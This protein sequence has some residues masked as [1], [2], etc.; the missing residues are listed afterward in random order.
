MKKIAII[1]KFDTS[2]GIADGQAVKTNIV[3]EEL[4]R[5]YGKNSVTRINTYAWKKHPVSLFARC[6][7]AVW[8]HKD[9][10]F[11]TDAGGIKVFPWLLLGANLFSDCKIHYLV[12]GG[13][14]PA[15][16]ENRKLRLWLLK[17]LNGIYV[18]TATMQ[19]AL[20]NRGLTNVSIVRNCKRLTPL[21][22]TDLHY[23][24]EGPYKLCTFS[25]VMREKGIQEAVEAVCAINMQMGK[26]VYTLDIYG[27]IDPEQT[28][29]FEVLQM[30]FP[31]F[32]RYCGT[33]PYDR[34]VTVLKDY[35]A[36]LRKPACPTGLMIGMGYSM[37]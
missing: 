12:V 27:Q 22:E 3:T 5:K 21:P 8:Y 24:S 26:T 4:E 2:L 7:F 6:F 13:W 15:T 31:D 30:E 9:V 11:M 19:Q 34:S 23:I 35:Y 33:V 14:L 18:E 28:E 32:V 25:R 1:G 29:W 10:I 20:E 16:L 36:L 37:P 17:K